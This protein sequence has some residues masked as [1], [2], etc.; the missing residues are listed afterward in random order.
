VLDRFFYTEGT[1]SNPFLAWGH[2]PWMVALSVGLAIA[3]STMAMHMVGLARTAAT[4]FARQAIVFSGALALGGGIWAMHFVGMLAFDLCAQGAFRPGTTALSVL[5]S[6]LA[7]LMAL[8]V[9]ARPTIGSRGATA[10]G[11]VVGAGI[12][13]MHYL[14]MSASSLSPVMRYDAAGFTAS[15]VFA[16]A[17][18]IAALH[19]RLWL[20]RRRDMPPWL[21]DVVG[22][23]VLGLAIAGMHYIS[24][25]ALRLAG[26]AEPFLVPGSGTGGYLPLAIAVVTMVL[27]MLITIASSALRHRRLYRQ[28]MATALHL[29]AVVDTAADGIVVID[30]EGTVQSFNGAA[31]RLL[32]WRAAE[33]LGRSAGIL[34]PAPQRGRLEQALRGDLEGGLVRI[35]GAVHEVQ[36]LRKDGS[37]V[38]I[39]LSVGR[40]EQP[41]RPVFV[42]FL[43]D[44]TE[45]KALEAERRRGEEQLRSLVGNIPGVAFRCRY[46]RDWAM[47]F[48]SDAVE[49]LTGWAA[50]DFTAGRIGFDRL[51][52]PDDAERAWEEVSCAVAAGRP[53]QL[54][55][56]LFARSGAL[57]WVSETG[58]GMAGAGDAV[59]W[60]DGVILDISE[61]KARN[62][63]FSGVLCALD[64][65]QAVAEFDL[66][67][68]LLSANANFLALM[69]YTLD[70]VAGQHH[71][72]FCTPEY[73]HD[74]A[75]GDMW[76]RLVGGEL[77][78]GEY[79]RLGKGGRHVWIQATYNPILD[80]EGRTTKIVKFATDLSGRRA[81]EQDLR[82]AKEHAEQAAQARA[83]FL[84]NMSHEIRTP[85]NAIIGFTEAL[86][87]TALDATQR[88]HLGI[89]HQASRSMLRLLND[90]LDTAKL[91][92]GA[93]ELEAADFSLQDLCEQIL[94]SLR[95][96]AAKKGLALEVDYPAGVPQF[97]RGDGFRVQQIL[98]NLL[99]NAIKFTHQGRVTLR[100]RQEDG[101]L[102]LAVE[103]TG[104]GID[105]ESMARIFDLFSQADASTTRRFGGT[106]LGTTIARQLAEL[107]GGSIAV[108]SAVGVGSTFTVR[109]PLPPAET[110]AS[111]RVL[112]RV[113][114]PPLRVLA[115]D[116][117]QANLELLEILLGRA[118][119]TVVCAPGG[120]A[121]VEAFASG[122]FDLVL[123]DLQMPDMD[124]LEATRLLREYERESGHRPTPIVALS[125]SVLEQD[126]RDARAAGMDGFASKP[127]EPA[128]L[129]Q[130]MARVLGLPHG[131]SAGFAVQAALRG[132]EAPGNEPLPVPPVSPV[133]PVP[134]IDWHR[135]L[136]VW[137]QPSALHRAIDRFMQD[138]HP[139][140]AS[141]QAAVDGEDWPEVA[142][143]A[144]RLRGA[145]GNLSLVR[146][147]TAA[148]VLERAARDADAALACSAM[149]AIAP[150]LESVREAL[151]QQ[152]PAPGAAA[153][154]AAGTVDPAL[155]WQAMEAMDQALARS[156]LAEAPL[157]LLSTGLPAADAAR[158]QETLDRFDFDAARAVLQALRSGR[159]VAEALPT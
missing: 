35:A 16:V 92:K 112:R 64:R 109:L 27:G 90:I 52:H 155:L 78:A 42:G 124:G 115:V 12:G 156:E 102:V 118:G 136:Q 33:V 140:A 79:Q 8:S 159:A 100:V 133:S 75:Y 77:D 144:H 5:P 39:R 148:D 48:I 87:D 62:A 65:A 89:A 157:A 149:Q 36:A 72:L 59:E 63:E 18:S 26:P 40:V 97:W 94:A 28:A 119:H 99:G 71:S 123:M 107:M 23:T 95:I 143:G 114:L 38:D 9:L 6:V 127:V 145:A 7:S 130:E 67:G 82:R 55:Y 69:G 104:I 93:V 151:R 116:D 137:S 142:R 31:E 110:A 96:H 15:V 57:V 30:A 88:R 83:T 47:L 80:A 43:V 19:A 147:Q 14:G 138:A 108:Q 146:L 25:D 70:E 103:D 54:E 84:A 10:G 60:L 4:V 76:D 141:L 131:A 20:Q 125:A 2:D 41:D 113:D 86:L 129:A 117:V 51:I 139:L 21:A 85:M 29:R 135:G 56:R 101:H 17:M 68:R 120:S 73:V 32:G 3:S 1:G 45:R 111:E 98:L 53:Y 37:C 61:A 134:P 13:L 11:A 154:A 46:Q 24:V 128:R 22:G 91:E 152:S 34:V 58:R 150:A 105:P 66:Q 74:P 81:M 122:R 106:G 121:A 49:A 132:A 50:A 44:L 153:S 158:L 126:R